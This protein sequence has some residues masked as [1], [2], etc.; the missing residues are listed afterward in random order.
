LQKV[1]NKAKDIDYEIE[2]DEEADDDDE[3]YDEDDNEEAVE[4]RRRLREIIDDQDLDPQ[5]RRALR[6]EKERRKRLEQKKSVKFIISL[7]FVF[8][9][10]NL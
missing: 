3:E 4:T 10:T 8:F 6:D 9:F 5:T 7:I 1:S 2:E